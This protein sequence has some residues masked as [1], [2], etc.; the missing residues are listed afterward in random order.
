[1]SKETMIYPLSDDAVSK[2]TGM[3]FFSK[4]EK[5]AIVSPDEDAP[6]LI[7]DYIE[8]VRSNEPALSGKPYIVEEKKRTIIKVNYKKTDN[9]TY[10]PDYLSYR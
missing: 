4:I 7:I 10:L 3:M 1:M 6:Y 9:E 2:L 5:I 8:T